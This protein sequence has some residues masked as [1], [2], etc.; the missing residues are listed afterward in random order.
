MGTGV[1]VDGTAVRVGFTVLVE[2]AIATA[3][4][5]RLVETGLLLLHADARKGNMNIPIMMTTNWRRLIGQIIPVNRFL[6]YAG[7]STSILRKNR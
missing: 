6:P 1:E 3:A 2:E 7:I 5:G 4:D